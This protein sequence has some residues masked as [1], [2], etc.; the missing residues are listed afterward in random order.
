MRRGALLLSLVLAL[1]WPMSLWAQSEEDAD[2]GYIQG[3]LEDALSAEGREVRLEGFRGALSSKAEIDRIVITDPDGI[4]LTADGVSMQWRR[5]ALLR[6]RVEIEE[7]RVDRLDLPRLPAPAPSEPPAPE[8]RGPVTLPDLPVSINLGALTVGSATLGAPVLGEA[9]EIGVSGSASLADGAG[10]GALEITRL[11]R[12]GQIAL[13]GRFVEET[14]QLTL[15]LN[16]NEPANGLVAT[17]LALPGAPAIDLSVNGDGPLDDFAA[18]LALATEGVD[19]LRG[20]VTLKGRETS[21]PDQAPDRAFDAV[22]A[23]D[24][25]PLLAPIYHDF[26]GEAVNLQVSGVQRGSGALDLEALDLTA[27]ALQL[28]GSAALTAGGWPE[29]FDLDIALTPPSGESVV[30]PLP[31]APTALSELALAARFDSAVGSAWQV[32]GTLAGLDHPDLMLDRVALNGAGQIDLNGQSVTGDLDLQASGLG[33]S[34]PALSTAVGEALSAVLDFDWAAGAP[35]QLR[36]IA[37]D[38]ADYGLAGTLDIDGVDGA[39]ALALRPDVTLQAQDL[40]RFAPLS[41]VDLA[42]AGGLEI[43][44]S[45]APVTGAFDL[46]LSGTTQDLAIGVAQVDPLLEGQGA[47]RLSAVRDTAGTRLPVLII[48]TDHATITAEADLSSGGTDARVAARVT[49]TARALP[50]LVGPTRLDLTVS[51]RDTAWQIDGTANLPGETALTVDADLDT[52]PAA[53]S[54]LDLKGRIGTLAT[55]ATLAGQPLR[56]GLTLDAQGSGSLEALAGTLRLTSTADDLGS[57]IPELDALLRGASTLD[58]AVARDA[59]GGIALEGLSLAASGISA[60]ASGQIGGALSGSLDAAIDLPDLGLVLPILPG[61]AGVTLQ[62]RQADT[63]WSLEA[64]A[65]GPGG[66]ALDANGSV[67][68]DASDVDLDLSGGAPLA[69]ANRFL[70]GQAI[71]GPLR[72]DLALRGAPG[73]EALSGQVSFDRTRFSAPALE[74]ALEDMA[75]RINLAGGQAVLD[76]TSRIAAGGGLSV[77]GPI[78]LAAP[79]NAALDIA[80]RQATLRKTGLVEAQAD[81]ALRVAGPLTGGAAISGDIL[82]D[83]IEMQIPNIGPSYSALDGLTHE[84]LPAD[85]RQ[86][87]LSAQLMGQVEPAP[88]PSYPVDLLVRA[89]NRIFVRGRGL[90]AE[91]GG[92]VRLTGRSDDIVPIGQF[93]LIRGR[94]EL[95]G[96]NV[97]LDEGLIS[98]QGSFDPVVSFSASSDVEGTVVTIGIE[99]PASD[100]EPSFT[101][102]PELPEDEVLSLFLFGRSIEEISTLQAVRLAAALRTLS[103]RGGLGITSGLREG[104]GV[105]NLDIGTDA[106]GNAEATVGTY[107]TETIYT[108]VTVNAEGESQVQLNL[109]V[110]DNVTVRGRATSDGDSAIGIFFERDY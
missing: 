61:P 1:L 103:G 25:T 3:L 60:D 109:D 9:V 23:G 80:L 82:F 95:L 21:A 89:P 94:L 29:R 53:D 11:D 90:D 48:S 101:S 42:G 34:D 44:G 24:V 85:V 30:L 50:G 87:L 69:L 102:V 67:A 100:P 16:A 39:L 45:V 51:G 91:L 59:E 79:F 35:L 66:I 84:A 110:S 70:D 98:L 2:R 55:Y 83:P 6:G 41:G 4:W 73:L 47:L 86:T 71:E 27:E 32:K 37:I 5:A 20:T 62:A 107:L 93:D 36:D 63:R 99:G 68:A 78:T 88:P 38:G 15:A 12:P 33:L 10:D 7:I 81:G 56:G 43:A 65:D 97:V 28:Q 17:R 58:L 57:G 14:Q 77:T 8:A 19:R 74:L 22:L 46:D 18:T 13:S 106:D 105:D 72:F 76:I 108:D 75:G 40:S 52:A 104:L 31:G 26:L 54:R 49:E 64:K 92:E 96:R